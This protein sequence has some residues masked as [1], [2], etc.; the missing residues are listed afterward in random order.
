[1]NT[2]L[3]SRQSD[4]THSSSIM[5]WILAA[6]AGTYPVHEAC[7]RLTDVGYWS[8]PLFIWRGN[9]FPPRISSLGRCDINSRGQSCPPGRLA[10]LLT[11]LRTSPEASLKCAE[12]TLHSACH[13]HHPRFRFRRLRRCDWCGWWRRG[14]LWVD[15]PIMWRADVLSF[16]FVSNW[17][18]LFCYHAIPPFSIA[19]LAK[20]F[21]MRVSKTHRINTNKV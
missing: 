7:P 12:K 5:M 8:S 15:A 17:V 4:L 16:R 19:L 11:R 10:R 18:F 1:M 13:H 6:S 9:F 20:K 14:S 21:W 3:E 2:I